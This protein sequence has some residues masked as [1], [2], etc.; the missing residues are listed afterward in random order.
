MSTVPYDYSTHLDFPGVLMATNN[1]SVRQQV[2]RALAERHWPLIEAASGADALHKLEA[3][4][5]QLLVMDEKQPDLQATE[6]AALIKDRY[7]GVDVLM[8][9]DTGLPATRTELKTEA[10]YD[11]LRV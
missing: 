11:L 1:A 2:T 4:E 5:C 3:S 10:A 9:D 8:L 7:P 6:L